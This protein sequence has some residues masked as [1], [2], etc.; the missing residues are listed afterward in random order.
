MY[1]RRVYA[2]AIKR[3]GIALLLPCVNRSHGDFRLEADGIRT[4][5]DAI[6]SFPQQIRDVLLEERCRNGPYRGLTDFRRRVK[7]GPEALRLLIEVGAFDFTG[8]PRTLLL[9]E[10][11]TE[12]GQPEAGSLFRDDGF[13]AM[14]GEWR[15][16][17]F[18]AVQ[19]WTTEWKRLGFVVGPTLMS[20]FRPGLPKDVNDSRDLKSH[21]GQ[22]VRMAGL[23]AVVR[24]ANT[25]QSKPMQFVTLEDEWGFV[26]AMLLADKCD[27][28]PYPGMGPYV[29]R[30]TL[31]E[32]HGVPV[33]MA[34]A[35]ERVEVPASLFGERSSSSPSDRWMSPCS[36]SS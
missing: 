2:E 9:L 24:H 23:V 27:I 11:E 8:L 7:S 26:D 1:P 14:L 19:K 30:G 15:P 5:F 33:V 10:V 17:D 6:A 20:L 31:E 12:P 13:E 35:F 4:G 36:K 3:A 29:V 25:R 21:V 18:T 34:E 28:I 32:H 22:M 16:D